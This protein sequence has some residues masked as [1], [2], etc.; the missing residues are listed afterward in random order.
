VVKDKPPQFV[1]NTLPIAAMIGANTG[2]EGHASAGHAGD[3][4]QRVRRRMGLRLRDVPQ[5]RAAGDAALLQ[6]GV[7][8]LSAAGQSAAAERV[9]LCTL[10]PG[11]ADSVSLEREC[12]YRATLLRDALNLTIRPVTFTRPS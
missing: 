6:S 8:Y 11:A 10:A 7:R 4:G 2:A 5:L 12:V 1:Q 3:G 9:V